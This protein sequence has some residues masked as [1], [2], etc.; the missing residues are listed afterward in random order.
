MHL[1]RPMSLSVPL[2]LCLLGS[3][4][5]KQEAQISLH[6]RIAAAHTNK[7]SRLP[8]A[9]SNPHVL[10]VENGYEVT[11][12]L[13]SKPQHAHVSTERLAPYLQA[14]PMQVWPRGAVIEMSPTDDVIVVKRYSEILPLPNTCA[15]A[16]D[17]RSGFCA[18][19]KVSRRLNCQHRSKNNS[20][21]WR[22][23]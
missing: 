15:E 2:A 8:D 18:E 17:L 14:L 9:C 20:R 6:D 3:G 23:S 4:C 11:S 21:L 13:G 10:A 5:R 19:G 1:L 16:W 7:Y 12:F 22:L